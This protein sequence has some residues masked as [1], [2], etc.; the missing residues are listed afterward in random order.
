MNRRPFF[1]TEATKIHR[2]NSPGKLTTNYTDFTNGSQEGR[3]ASGA[4]KCSR[5]PNGARAS[6]V[7]FA[8]L[9]HPGGFAYG[10][11]RPSPDRNP[12]NPVHP[13]RNIGLMFTVSIRVHLCPSVVEK[14]F[15]LKEIG[16]KVAGFRF[17]VADFRTSDLRPR[18][19]DLGPRPK[20]L[21]PIP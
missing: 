5:L 19:S 20:S 8:R 4:G 16:L 2:E 12:I 17:Q 15:R 14:R 10:N 6:R 1:T 7:A 18:T 3:C 21:R 11:P 9:G 13:V